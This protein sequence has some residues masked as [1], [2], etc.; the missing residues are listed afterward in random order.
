MTE[1]ISPDYL[2]VGAGCVGMGFADSL[3]A[4]T[5]A[6]IAIVDSYA[7]PGGHWT[8]AYPFVTLHQP[9]EAY[10]VNSRKLGDGKIDQAGLN[11][12]YFELATGDEI[13][14]YYGRVMHSTLLPSGRVSY[15]PLHKY[16]NDGQF[17]SI[18][19]GKRY[20]VG[21]NTRIVD[22]SY[23]KVTVPSMRPP[24]YEV[25]D[26]VTVTTPN[27]LTTTKRPY[28]AYTLVG[29]GKTA[30]DSSK[31]AE[32]FMKSATSSE[33]FE[34]MEEAGYALRIDKNV[35]PTMM[36]IGILA[37]AEMERVRVVQNII[38]LG[39][40]IR[41]DEDKVT[42]DKGTYTPVPDTLYIDCSAAGFPYRPV[43]PIFNGRTITV[44][45]IKFA[46]PSFSSA[47]LALIDSTYD[48]DEKKNELCNPIPYCAK[49]ADF[50][51]T[52][53]VY[54]KNRLKWFEEPKLMAWVE[55]SR[56]DFSPLGP[57]P[58]DPEEAAKHKASI[59]DQ[60]RALCDKF[61]EIVRN[62]TAIASTA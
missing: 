3:V 51:H 22:T 32:I 49:P 27:G 54:L 48:S 13:V 41:I 36:K 34:R 59:P 10:G 8:I 5:K 50:V 43:V 61:E 37:K 4:E 17:H 28:S 58:T 45:N 31:K 40:V 53:L 18:A 56:L 60:L 26:K 29:A 42:L 6:T 16:T 7:R 11:K 14:G 9:S 52:F 12:G 38:R 46:Q 25:S 24:Q 21:P 2:I 33:M 15:Y 23:S 62:D 44:Q 1:T 39:H 57:P 20:Q 30:F 19:T 47:L 35:Q 55:R